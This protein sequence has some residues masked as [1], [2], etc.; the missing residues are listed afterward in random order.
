MLPQKFGFSTVDGFGADTQNTR[1]AATICAMDVPLQ[2]GHECSV[3]VGDGISDSRVTWHFQPSGAGGISAKDIIKKWFDEKWRAE[4][5]NH[6]VS[7]IR[8][9]FAVLSDL[10]AAA[11]QRR[12]YTVQNGPGIGTPS[13]RKAA[14]L[15]ALGHPVIGWRWSGD[16]C[17]WRF[18]ECAA[19][20]A[21]MLE[22][23]KLY[24]RL[25]TAAIS[26]ARAALFGHEAMVEVARRVTGYR[27]Q[28]KGRIA[29]VSKELQKSQLD[30]IEK[31]L[32]RR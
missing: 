1:L 18:N 11:S 31:L 12:G 20:D 6:P 8:K 27:I 26:Y 2:E 5:P 13:T 25:P 19:A 3:T 29:I 30:Q 24:D 7:I 22:D 14:I 28:H 16:A 4:N 15:V 17:F 23:P 10:N 32:Y 9:A 21:A